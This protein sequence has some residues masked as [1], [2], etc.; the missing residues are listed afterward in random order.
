MRSWLIHWLLTGVA[1]LIVAKILP[2]I[3]VDSFGAALIAATPEP[4]S[5]AL[6]GTG[7][8]ALTGAVRRKLCRA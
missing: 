7:L 5:L 4:T 1:L 8:L 2:G 6:L 3:E